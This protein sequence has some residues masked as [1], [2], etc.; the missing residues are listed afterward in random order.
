MKIAPKLVVSLAGQRKMIQDTFIPVRLWART[1]TTPSRL[2]QH[3]LTIPVRNPHYSS[4]PHW[5]V[6]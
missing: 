4:V 6:A 5:L 3:R 1:G 2:P